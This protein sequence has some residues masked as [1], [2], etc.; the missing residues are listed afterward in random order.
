MKDYKKWFW[1]KAF[2]FKKIGVIV[3]SILCL[4]PLLINSITLKDIQLVTNE[5]KIIQ[6][7]NLEGI[8]DVTIDHRVVD[9]N[10]KEWLKNDNKITADELIGYE[11]VK[12]DSF[13][14]YLD[15][16]QEIDFP[17]TIK[18]IEPG[19]IINGRDILKKVIIP[20]SVTNLEGNIF[21]DCDLDELI[22]ENNNLFEIVNGCVYNKNEKKL[23]MVLPSAADANHTI[24][25]KP[26]T[27]IIAP[28]A[29]SNTYGSGKYTPFKLNMD[30]FKNVARIEDYA[31][32]Q[33]N[34]ENFE[35]ST[36]IEYIGKS[37]FSGF[38]GTIE[39]F[40]T[41][42]KIDHYTK[43]DILVDK[44]NDNAINLINK[45]WLNNERFDMFLDYT[46]IGD[47]FCDLNNTVPLNN[48]IFGSKVVT[49]GNSA[50]SNLIVK[51]ILFDNN[52]KLNTIGD[53]AFSNINNGQGN[54]LTFNINI[55]NS[56]EVIGESL[57]Y[58]SSKGNV[59]IPP[60]VK[61]IGTGINLNSAGVHIDIDK[62]NPYYQMRGGVYI[63]LKKA[64][65]ICYDSDWLLNSKNQGKFIIDEQVKYIEPRSL[66]ML[67][68]NPNFKGINILN[69]DIIIGNGAFLNSGVSP[70]P[71]YTPLDIEVPEAMDEYTKRYI[72]TSVM[73][74]EFGPIQ[75][76]NLTK[77]GGGSWRGTINGVNNLLPIPEPEP[78]PPPGKNST[79]VLLDNIPK[80]IENF[81]PSNFINLSNDVFK[82]WFTIKNPSTDP[83][84]P[85]QIDIN[86]YEFNNQ[87]G[88]IKIGINIINPLINNK[89]SD[90]I[91]SEFEIKGLKKSTQTTLSQTIFP[92]EK[93]DVPKD[94][95]TLSHYFDWTDTGEIINHDGIKSYT[96]QNIIKSRYQIVEIL[97]TKL[98]EQY[99]DTFYDYKLHLKIR[100]DN[101]YDQNGLFIETSQYNYQPMY[102]TLKLDGFKLIRQKG[103]L[104]S[105][106]IKFNMIIIFIVIGIII[107]CLILAIILMTWKRKRKE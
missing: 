7:I 78:F 60:N 90:D 89:L 44:N 64:S 76:N 32:Y 47:N 35:I 13:S 63:D 23:L 29:F 77:F 1:K 39:S 70:S 43:F 67:M 75:D 17:N 48:L 106:V 101:Y 6:K 4:S 80:D 49:I 79:I 58:N 83:N 88:T 87:D 51:E 24:R 96:N 91:Y 62:N 102:Y 59:Y 56:V 82:Q 5:K 30:D 21:I 54:N 65:V 85:T 104:K 69:K 22:I 2:L 33:A 107:L 18:T 27:E 61:S 12:S 53:F 94:I 16:V 34:I 105:D 38:E 3:L 25:I 81:L 19:S 57:F 46:I 97:N 10:I 50:F 37:S 100:I 42:Y 95:D 84:F 8:D 14:I 86:K 11:Y 93:I 66:T 74:W 20:N 71:N 45:K 9:I 72:I 52:S 103:K 26:D 36:K 15:N 68:V 98:G 28:Y 99:Y 40:N 41:N 31:F 55:P 73:S 92:N